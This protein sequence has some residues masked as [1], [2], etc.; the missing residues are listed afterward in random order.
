MRPRRLVP[1]PQTATWADAYR[2]GLGALMLALGVTILVR[3]IS[4]GVITLPAMIMGLAF[5][6]FGTYRLY[7]GAVRY[8]MYRALARGKK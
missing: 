4:L 7:V 1:P 8:R 6:G 5:I 2:T 3:S